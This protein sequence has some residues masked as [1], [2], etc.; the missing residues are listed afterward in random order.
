VA[1]VNA[2]CLNAPSEHEQ[3]A[4]VYFKENLTSERPGQYAVRTEIG[5]ES[6][7]RADRS[8]VGK[9]G[10]ADQVLDAKPYGWTPLRETKWL[11]YRPSW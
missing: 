4:G 5:N 9:V 11:S 7:T 3:A 1:R 10:T 8:G 6:A 2:A